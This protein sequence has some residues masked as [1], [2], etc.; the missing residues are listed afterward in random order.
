MITLSYPWL[1]ALIALIFVATLILVAS[2]KSPMRKWVCFTISAIT[3]AYLLYIMLWQQHESGQRLE[4]YLLGCVGIIAALVLS[5]VGFMDLVKPI[6]NNA[7][8]DSR[9]DPSILV[10]YENK[11]TDTDTVSANAS[12]TDDTSVD[13]VNTDVDSKE[14]MVSA[15][16][17]EAEDKEYAENGL[18]E[19]AS[20]DA[21]NDANNDA[22]NE[23]ERIQREE[24]IGKVMPWFLDQLNQYDEKEQNSIKVCAIEFVYEG[25]ISNPSIDI[26]KNTLYSQQRLMELCSAFVLLDKDRLDCAEFAKTVFSP[27]FSNTEIST[28]EK[29]I[30]GRDKMQL[31]VDSYWE[32]IIR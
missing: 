15:D 4:W 26:S 13:D 18:E 22:L 2:Y 5:G 6:T 27:T 29:K 23:A 30:R 11:E 19:D 28:L 7:S 9:A 32:A 3:I 16:V 8:I 1:V 10:S 14:E 24:L 21:K 17:T 25:T 12:G 31:L 20:V